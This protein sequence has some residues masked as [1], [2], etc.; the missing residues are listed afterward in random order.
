MMELDCIVSITLTRVFMPI[1]CYSLIIVR[2]LLP[3]N[4]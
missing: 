1:N 2:F 3:I 4:S